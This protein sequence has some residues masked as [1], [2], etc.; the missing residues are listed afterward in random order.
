MA[1]HWI[2]AAT[3]YF[4]D[5]VKTVCACGAAIVHRPWAP[6][7]AA[8]ICARCGAQLL[9]GRP[10]SAVAVDVDERAV[11]EARLFLMGTRGLQ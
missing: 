5:D 10:Q 7:A 8:K 3:G 4:A 9:T 1:S 2:C 11:Q 6:A